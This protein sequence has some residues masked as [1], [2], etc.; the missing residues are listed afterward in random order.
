MK[1][2]NKSIKLTDNIIIEG[3]D[4]SPKVSKAFLDRF[5]DAVLKGIPD[6]IEL[7]EYLPYDEAKAIVHELKVDG[8]MQWHQYCI[9]DNKPNNIP[10][11]PEKH[12]KNKGW[13]DWSDWMGTKP[14]GDLNEK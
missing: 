11:N 8:W 5:V 10:S 1:D 9:S 4:L 7:D 6:P 12:Y 3:L 14:K 2:K 13:V